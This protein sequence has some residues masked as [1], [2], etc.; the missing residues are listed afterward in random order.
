M[1]KLYG[2]VLFLLIYP[3]V[4]F[5]QKTDSLIK[6]LDSVSKVDSDTGKNGHN[7][8]SQENY[9]EVTKLTGKTYMILL[10]SDVK[11]EF[12][13]PFHIKQ[14]DYWKVG[15]FVLITGGLMIVDES[16]NRY[17]M[18]VRANSPP[19]VKVSKYVTNFGGPYEAYTLAALGIYGWVFENEKIKTTTLLATQAYICGSLLE[20]LKFVFGR[21]R[22]NYVDP[23]THENDPS[24]H[25]PLY[26]FHKNIDGTR[27]PVTSYSSF[28]SGHS[29]VAFAAAT[30]FA[31]EYRDRPLVPVLAY[32]A[33]S[34][35]G[36]S[37]ITENRHW[38]S[39]VF[40]GATLGY[41]CGKLVVNNY[42]RYNKVQKQNHPMSVTLVPL[43]GKI[44]PGILYTL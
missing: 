38:S 22:P 26:P 7:D 37:R 6:K 5:C 33:A 1:K 13:A 28:P 41:L 12:S 14:K 20:S 2:L 29:I 17:A 23:Q 10:V 34:L 40:A 35:I 16:I 27:P 42:H 15:T 24:W 18:Q 31:M 30:V 43:N 25:G 36:L 39:D 4:C 21:Q 9:N 19:V 32:S 3:A 8:I 44:L 11:Q